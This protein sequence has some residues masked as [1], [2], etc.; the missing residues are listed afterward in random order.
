MTAACC[1]LTAHPPDK[2][3]FSA[4]TGVGANQA[5]SCTSSCHAIRNEELLV[6]M[7]GP[8]PPQRIP[9]DMHPAWRSSGA[10]QPPTCCRSH[11][12]TRA[13]PWSRARAA[14]APTSLHLACPIGNLKVYHLQQHSQNSKV[15][16]CVLPAKRSRYVEWQVLG[17]PG[18]TSKAFCFRG[19]GRMCTSGWALAM[20]S[21]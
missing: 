2:D 5:Q 17:V 12:R 6:S 16:H 1:Q 9:H 10:A 3:G 18:R 4:A 20:V 7:A 8:V 21:M 15:C 19:K 11:S 14:A 13:R